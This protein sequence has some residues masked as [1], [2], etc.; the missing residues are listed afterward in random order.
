M[1]GGPSVP[2]GSPQELCSDA[3]SRIAPWAAKAWQN[4]GFELNIPGRE[5]GRD[6][7]A[8]P[9]GKILVPPHSPLLF[10]LVRADLYLSCCISGL[11]YGC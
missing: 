3:T 9:V 8:S 11:E 6:V 1:D 7:A 2:W 4:L 5:A 10:S